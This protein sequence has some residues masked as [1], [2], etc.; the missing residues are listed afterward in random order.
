MRRKYSD[1]EKA[2]ALA[3]HDSGTTLT[4]LSKITGIP[5]STLSQWINGRNGM[6]A[7]IPQLRVEQKGILADEIENVVWQLLHAIPSKIKKAGLGAVSTSMGIGIDKVRLL[8]DQP[9]VITESLANP[10][11]RADKSAN[12]IEEW[13]R[14]K[15]QKTA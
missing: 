11:E 9:T 5:D 7:D 2:E 6:N 8:R 14:R 4:E 12:M 15:V 1:R 10:V 13:K 3:L